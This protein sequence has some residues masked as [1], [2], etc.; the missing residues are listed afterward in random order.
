MGAGA[1]KP[2]DGWAAPNDAV[3]VPKRP[4]EGWLV[5][6]AVPPNIDV[7]DP[8]PV[9]W[10]DGAAVPVGFAPKDDCPNPVDVLVPKP[11]TVLIVK[12]N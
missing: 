7:L 6:V 5:V 10:K 2:V 11:P 9:L 1:P 3:W 8:N 4:P 12:Y